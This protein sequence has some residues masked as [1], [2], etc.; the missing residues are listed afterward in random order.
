MEKSAKNEKR[1]W[2]KS[3]KKPGPKKKGKMGFSED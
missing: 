2:I 1:P 3:Q